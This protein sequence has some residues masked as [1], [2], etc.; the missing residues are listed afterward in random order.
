MIGSSWMIVIPVIVLANVVME[1]E[2][3]GTDLAVA[4]P[5]AGCVEAE[6]YGA[7]RCHE[8]E[9]LTSPSRDLNYV[10]MGESHQEAPR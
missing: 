3:P 8:E 9:F 6:N 10:S 1:V 7:N 4:V 2:Q 5:V